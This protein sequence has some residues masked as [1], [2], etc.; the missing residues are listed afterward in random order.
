VGGS[1]NL[2]EKYKRVTKE[3]KRL[4]QLASG[5]E[6]RLIAIL[7]ERAREEFTTLKDIRK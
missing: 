7:Q 3:T 2:F 6:A 4:A 5:E 1:L